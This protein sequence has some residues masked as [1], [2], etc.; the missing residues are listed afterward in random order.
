[1]TQQPI[2]VPERQVLSLKEVETITGRGRK[3]AINELQTIYDSCGLSHEPNTRW[4]VPIELYCRE[5]GLQLQA[6]LTQL[7]INFTIR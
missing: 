3:A 5:K 4:H 7:N 1:M 2:I 6:V